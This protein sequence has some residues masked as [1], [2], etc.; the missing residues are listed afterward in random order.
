MQHAVVNIIYIYIHIYIH[1]YI[2]IS[3]K[4]C[5]ATYRH[6]PIIVC[7]CLCSACVVL[8]PK[9]L[10]HA[11]IRHA[12]A[13]CISTM[14]TSTTHNAT[15]S[16]ASAAAQLRDLRHKIPFVS[17]SALAAV[18]SLPRDEL[19]E[20]VDRR[21]IREARDDIAFT[22]TPYGPVHQTIEI[23]MQDGKKR[24]VEVQH[25]AAMLYQLCL[26][27]TCFSDLII[28]TMHR[29][30]CSVDKPW[31]VIIYSDQVSPGN[32]LLA[33][34]TRKVWAF[35]WSILEFGLN[36]LSDEESW[37][38]VVVL[39][40]PI[41]K[42]IKGAVSAVFAAVLKL[43]F[44]PDG[45]DCSKAGI[46]L[47]LAS[48]E[49]IRIWLKFLFKLGDEEAL[50]L[51]WG[52]KGTGGLKCCIKCENCF[53]R[54]NARGIGTDPTGWAQLDHCFDK[55]K[56]VKST[57]ESVFK[58][59][60]RLLEVKRDSPS[61]L[62][63]AQTNLG[64]NLVVGGVMLVMC[65]RSFLDPPMQSY[66][67]SMHICYVGGLF[68]VHVGLLMEVLH[69][70]GITYATLF[71]YAQTWVWPYR[72]RSVTGVSA[73]GK[74]RAK[75][76]KTAQTFKAAASEGRCLVPILE[77]FTHS[78]LM[79]MN[80][81]VKQHAACFLLLIEVLQLLECT[82]RGAVTPET[83]EGALLPYLNSFKHL[84]GTESLIDKHHMSLHLIEQ[85]MYGL[86]NCFVLERKHKNAKRFSNI[87]MNTKSNWDASAL[88]EIT[89]RHI[90]VLQHGDAVHFVE[91]A[92]L[93]NYSRPSKKFLSCMHSLF[94]NDVGI[95]TST[96][97]RINKWESCSRGDVVMI[98]LPNTGIAVGR[99]MFHV[100][101]RSDVSKLLCSCIER[102]VLVSQCDM[103]SEWN[104]SSDAVQLQLIETQHILLACIYSERNGLA[105]VLHP[106]LTRV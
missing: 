67:D 56:L 58:I 62:G 17:Q 22:N 38:E 88:R 64:W 96:T 73:F 97:A 34:N 28:R 1:I 41:V 12:A 39:R 60:D 75:G 51:A 36:V 65:L 8:L 63:A 100:D 23:E 106:K 50:H 66:Y 90:A 27:S 84:Y 53:H 21:L 94:G 54:N 4:F 81:T 31:S 29:Y 57:K 33:V 37:M 61:A 86:P 5:V 46:Y 74:D 24:D 43:F 15:S 7:R 76:S 11:C 48:G 52:C 2:Y 104:C 80:D 98:G 72:L 77:K 59:I 19:P 103:Y 83:F 49:T 69:A 25:P 30:P 91:H 3:L 16:R 35:Y 40:N 101:V 14:S 26:V 55:T 85:I 13:I 68:N 99:V 87:I 47:R 20:A 89:S 102:W 70:H 10:F 9:V 105:T 32:Q 95:A 93:Q 78:V 44:D 18:L 71:E 79:N 45:H 42:L 6:Q 82:A 92:C